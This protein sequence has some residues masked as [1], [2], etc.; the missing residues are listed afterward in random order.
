[1]RTV[2]RPRR[3]VEQH[4]LLLL[5]PVLRYS[6]SR[7]AYLLRGVGNR[8]G[9]VLRPERRATQRAPVDGVDRRQQA[10]TA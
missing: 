8:I 9:P 7:R 4:W 6:S 5:M 2:P 10:S 1:M 3:Y